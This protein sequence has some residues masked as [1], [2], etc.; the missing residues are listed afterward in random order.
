MEIGAC[1]IKGMLESA[2]YT[3]TVTPIAEGI[4]SGR[5]IRTVPRSM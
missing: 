1:A 4:V 3:V 2:G 5:L